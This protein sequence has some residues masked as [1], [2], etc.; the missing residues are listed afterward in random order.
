MIIHVCRCLNYTH[1][2]SNCM[3]VF[4]VTI[5]V[6]AESS[7]PGPTGG[8]AGLLAG[9]TQ[10]DAITVDCLQIARRR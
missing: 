2:V 1:V 6:A 7:V 10:R 5:P 9:Q 3:Y 8:R 4:S